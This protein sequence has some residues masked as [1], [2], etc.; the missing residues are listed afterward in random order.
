M[1]A[2]VFTEAIFKLTKNTRMRLTRS[3]EE[4]IP[5]GGN[6]KYARKRLAQHV[7]NTISLCVA[8]L[9][10]TICVFLL[11]SLDPSW[12]AF[13]QRGLGSLPTTSFP[14]SSKRILQSTSTSP[15]SSQEAESIATTALNGLGVTF[16]TGSRS[17][18][19]LII[20]HLDE[21]TTAGELRLFL[22]TLHRS[23]ATAK[24]DV[25]L[26]FPLSPVSKSMVDVIEEEERS[27]WEMML[28]LQSAAPPHTI[29]ETT[30]TEEIV[31]GASQQEK[32]PRVQV[33]PQ[34]SN[35]SI[36][37]FHGGAFWKA[38]EEG[39][40]RG[41]AL[42]GR[43]SP[44]SEEMLVAV[45]WADWGSLV[46]FEMQDLDWDE[47]LKGFIDE[48]G[49]RL[50][51]WISY[52]MLLGMVK[53]KFRHVLLAA[54]GEV[55]IMGDVLS[56]A[57]KRTL[58][59]LLFQEDHSWKE[60]HTSLS[61]TINETDPESLKSHRPDEMDEHS[62]GFEAV[63]EASESKK[64]LS[65]NESRSRILLS[66]EEVYGKDKWR[67]L[68]EEVKEKPVL[69]TGLIIGHMKPV[70]SL[71]STMATEIAGVASLVRKSRESF[72]D[73]PLLNY[74]VYKSNVLN[75][76]VTG[77]LHIL[78]NSDSSVHSLPASKQ[79]SIFFR[80]AGG[81]YAALQGL[82]DELLDS[83]FYSSAVKRISDDICD[84]PP[85]S[86]FYS[87]CGKASSRLTTTVGE[88]LMGDVLSG[89]QTRSFDVVLG[90]EDHSRKELRTRGLEAAG[91]GIES[92]KGLSSNESQQSNAIEGGGLGKGWEVI[93]ARLPASRVALRIITL[94][95]SPSGEVSVGDPALRADAPSTCHRRP[96][97]IGPAPQSPSP[98][99]V[100][101]SRYTAQM[102]WRRL[103]DY[104]KAIA[105]TQRSVW[106]NRTTPPYEYRR[107]Y[108]LRTAAEASEG[109]DWFVL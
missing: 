93:A 57:R 65:S 109:D 75:R 16:R 48:P 28:E 70:R 11:C 30:S 32:L 14:G 74:L 7:Q 108:S 103:L 22:R 13:G 18:N 72:H 35:C 43:T 34:N 86:K 36:S 54:V 89:A 31:G 91:G 23:G 78:E 73:R 107:T 64:G 52:Q 66:I 80:N 53:S 106:L 68:E 83:E 33:V 82:K 77:K 105:E 19:E 12:T 39:K 46:G 47:A 15:I 40:P 26:L 21:T 99:R 100:T 25:V 37:R 95:T 94:D 41:D 10:V 87:N 84:S 55:V 8:T 101:G 45:D 29:K 9:V 98:A 63:G 38:R 6:E 42:W 96:L 69:G 88:V 50:R 17:M 60:L 90:K 85:D 104:M 97:R 61:Q 71:V 79:R 92:R 49:A 5:G 58:D 2:L 76:R 1:R 24:A 20:A 81:R 102:L 27:W 59:V 67:L 56:A 3:L 4:Y 44:Q 51:R 62:Q